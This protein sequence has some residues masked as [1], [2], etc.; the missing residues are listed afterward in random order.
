[1]QATHDNI[2]RRKR[3]ACWVIRLQTHTQRMQYLLLFSQQQSFREKATVLHFYV[4]CLSCLV[5]VWFVLR[6]TLTALLQGSARSV[7]F[8]IVPKTG[9]ASS[10]FRDRSNV[11]AEIS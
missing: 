10:R 2:A 5:D 7:F 8:C 4:H 3:F 1:M 6:A 11:K 9:A